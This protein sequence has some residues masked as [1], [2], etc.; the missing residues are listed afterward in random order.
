M[1]MRAKNAESFA[2]AIC[3][4]ALSV[5]RLSS[6]WMNPIGK[7]ESDSLDLALEIADGRRGSA[8][9]LVLPA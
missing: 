3:S 5:T 6:V 1:P 2:R 4:P 8:S 7:R 9:E